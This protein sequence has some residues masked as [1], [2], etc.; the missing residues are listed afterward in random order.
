MSTVFNL[1]NTHLIS[2]KDHLKLQ[3]T[4]N[5]TLFLNVISFTVSFSLFSHRKRAKKDAKPNKIF[6]SA[7]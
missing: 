3:T 2:F 4:G 5:C 7:R 1:E 6:F